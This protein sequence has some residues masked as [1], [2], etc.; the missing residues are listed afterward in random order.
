M[1][2][3]ERLFYPPTLKLHSPQAEHSGQ[4]GLQNYNAAPLYGLLYQNCMPKL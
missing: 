1:N 2:L 4:P 3:A